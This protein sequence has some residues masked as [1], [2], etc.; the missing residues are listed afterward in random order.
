ML[1]LALLLLFWEQ[2]AHA[3]VWVYMDDKGVAHFSTQQVDARYELFSRSGQGFDTGVSPVDGR[4]AGEGAV[5]AS[6]RRLQTFFDVSPSYKSVRHH[7]R[8]ASKRHDIDLELLQALI[9][10]ESGF[11]ARAV[12]PRGATG[13]MQIMPATAERYGVRADRRG[14]V[15]TKLFDP[16]VNIAT[17]ARYLAYLIKLFPGQLEL[18][19]AAYNA[20]EGT[21]QRAGNKI[22]NYKETQDYVATVMRLYTLL[23][24]P[25][26]V[27]ELRSTPHRLRMELPG[28]AARRGNMLA[29]LP[30]TVA[31]NDTTERDY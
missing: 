18:A 20:G 21:V 6:Q 2:A 22:P 9:A 28:G 5:L 30:S 31:T 7:L 26:L 4:T 24:P 14:T 8:E 12:S 27:A 13:L 17:G 23:K 19:L 25:V 1:V 10:T 15:Q 3:D 29:P 11:D 16:D